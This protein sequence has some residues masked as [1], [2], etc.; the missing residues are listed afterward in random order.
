M[1]GLP[2]LVAIFI[3]IALLLSIFFILINGFHDTANAV[4]SVIY[5]NAMKPEQAVFSSAFFNFLGVISGGIGV[6]LSIIYLLPY[7]IIHDQDLKTNLVMVYSMLL[8]A[9]IWNLGTWYVGIPSSSSH[10]LIG[11]ILGISFALYINK[12]GEYY[13]NLFD[14]EESKKLIYGLII[15]PFLGFS[16]AII[17]MIILKFYYRNSKL[18]DE[19]F[20]SQEKTHQPPKGIK[21]VLFLSSNLVSFF[22]GKNDGQKGMGLIMIVLISLL[23]N[24]FSLNPDLN[25]KELKNEI[26]HLENSIPK[27]SNEEFSKL[28][29]SINNFQSISLVEGNEKDIRKSIIA[30]NQEVTSLIN[31]KNTSIKDSLPSLNKSKSK[32]NSFVNYIPK[33][34]VYLVSLVLAFGTM[35]GWKRIVITIGE[36]IG[37]SEITYAQGVSAELVAA[38]TIGFASVLSLPVSTTHTLS[39]G[40]SGTMV[41]DKGFSNLQFNTVIK[42]LLIWLLTLPGTCLLTASNFIFLKLIIN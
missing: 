1:F 7:E 9:I 8:S 11:A 29:S 18:K 42:I 3:V 40:I 25:Y 27:N 19:L 23:P 26:S 37:R 34:V 13:F 14:W 20:E 16:L 12:D 30:I 22:H 39:S 15:A 21:F 38:S 10:A 24:I 6:G 41:A 31:S 17:L 33:W 4:T 5:T 2:I 35:I 28:Q 36:K 32:L